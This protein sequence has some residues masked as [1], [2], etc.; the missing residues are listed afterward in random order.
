MGKQPIRH[1]N[2]VN[3]LSQKDE[4]MISLQRLLK[5]AKVNVI[6]LLFFVGHGLILL[7]NILLFFET[8]FTKY[9]VTSTEKV[10][11]RPWPQYFRPF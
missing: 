3:A 8:I 10:K 9:W 5:N 7:P 6:L 11:V 2:P 1:I 4:V